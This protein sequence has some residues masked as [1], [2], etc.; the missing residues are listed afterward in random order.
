MFNNLFQGNAVSNPGTAGNRA[1]LTNI[2]A[3]MLS[4][5]IGVASIYFPDL[6][7]KLQITQEDVLLVASALATIITAANAYYHI[8]ANVEAGLKK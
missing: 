3:S 1:A 8:A 5:M 2:I 7:T 4:V 6:Q